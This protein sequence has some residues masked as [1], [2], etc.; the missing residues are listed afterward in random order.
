MKRPPV[1]ALVLIGAVLTLLSGGILFVAGSTRASSGGP[2]GFLD[3]IFLLSLLPG[4]LL[5]LATGMLYSERPN[6]PLAGL[7]GIVGSLASIPLALAGFWVGFVLAIFGSFLVLRRANGRFTTL[8]PQGSGSSAPPGEST[9]RPRQGRGWVIPAGVTIVVAV[10]VLLVAP[11]T[12]AA[13]FV[14]TTDLINDPVAYDLQAAY[15]AGSGGNSISYQVNAVAQSANCPLGFAYFVNAYTN[16]SGN[17]NWYQAGLS[18]DWG[19]GTFSSS[20]WGLAYEVWGPNGDSIFPT[21]SPGAG[22]ASFSGALNSGDPVVVTLSLGAGGV[23]F[24]AEDS[25][26]HASASESYAAAGS[27]PFGGVMPAQNPGYFTGVMTEC[28]RNDASSIALNSV[29][30]TQQG[31][32]QSM[33]GVFVE[34]IN[35]SWG[36]FPYLPSL[37]LTEIHS[38]LTVTSFVPTTFQAYGLNLDYSATTF[39]VTTG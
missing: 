8:A 2:Y 21:A 15:V 5:L 23:S 9:P 36:R 24:A 38:N 18:Y 34:E 27:A 3:G 6:E 7:L 35:F 16:D 19:G 33:A 14:E 17:L 26:T 12:V 30:F 13:D 1:R 29:T 4:V 39:A 28:Y 10:V 11:Q 31:A 22:V 20:G 32:S 25:T 37:E